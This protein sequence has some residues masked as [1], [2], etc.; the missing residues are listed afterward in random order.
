MESCL[1]KENQEAKE[2][3]KKLLSHASQKDLLVPTQKDMGVREYIKQYNEKCLI[4]N[5][6][7]IANNDPTGKFTSQLIHIDEPPSSKQLDSFRQEFGEMRD[8]I[9]NIDS[10]P[11]STE[12]SLENSMEIE[13]PSKVSNTNSS[14]WNIERAFETEKRHRLIFDNDESPFSNHKNSSLRCSKHKFNAERSPNARF[15][16]TMKLKK[17]PQSSTKF[18]KNKYLMNL[19]K[20]FN[21]ANTRLQTRTINLFDATEDQPKTKV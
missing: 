5:V 2:E 4:T 11:E 20:K 14:E 10:K 9:K 13:S 12:K 19:E 21:P 6:S 15:S 8:F 7:S 18:R 17:N 3:L 16:Q 1:K